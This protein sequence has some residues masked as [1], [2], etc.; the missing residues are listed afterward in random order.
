MPY[1]NRSIIVSKFGGYL[2]EIR[3][4]SEF[5]NAG[6]ILRMHRKFINTN[7]YYGKTLVT[8]LKLDE[9]ASAIIYDYATATDFNLATLNGLLTS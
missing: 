3:V 1:A 8:Y 4:W 2:R 6:N 9:S 7:L 5:I